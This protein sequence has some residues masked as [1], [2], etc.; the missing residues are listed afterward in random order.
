MVKA[1]F[2]RR[3]ALFEPLENADL[4]GTDLTLAIH[5][6]MMEHI[7]DGPEPS[8]DLRQL[9]E[10]GRL[11]VKTGEGFMRWSPERADHLRRTLNRHLHDT[12]G[13]D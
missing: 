9:V 2:G 1:S 7:E 3:L 13:Q 8:P 11:G 10:D 4:I 6:I 12:L 5:P